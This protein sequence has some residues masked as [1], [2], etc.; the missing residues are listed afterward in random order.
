MKDL[1]LIRSYMSFG[2][3]GAV[4]AILHD[5]NQDISDAIRGR[6]MAIPFITWFKA[7][8]A[9]CYWSGL[10][11]HH[12][13]DIKSGEYPRDHEQLHLESGS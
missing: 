13:N 6:G 11:P 9:L 7:Y 10:V 1:E 5:M 12:I 3:D 2:K 4:N 8:Q